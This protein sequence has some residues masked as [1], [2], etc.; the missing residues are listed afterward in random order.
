[1]LVV[2][3]KSATNRADTKKKRILVD[4]SNGASEAFVKWVKPSKFR[5]R[6]IVFFM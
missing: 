6:F 2:F 5:K 1:M 4:T 3:I